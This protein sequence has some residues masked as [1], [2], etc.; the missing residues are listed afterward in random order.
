MGSK[1]DEQVKAIEREMLKLQTII[2]LQ[3]GIDRRYRQ[4]IESARAE[5]S[6]RFADRDPS[7]ACVHVH[8]KSTAAKHEH[9]W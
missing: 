1:G 3:A 2:T 9:G 7:D 6:R 5:W 8:V 4:L